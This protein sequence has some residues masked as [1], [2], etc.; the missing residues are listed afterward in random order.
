[1]KA[2]FVQY[3]QIPFSESEVLKG[4]YA[5]PF[6]VDKLCATMVKWDKGAEFGPDEHIDE[7]I[8]FLLEGKME[9]TVKDDDGER[10]VIVT[11]G[12]AIGLDPYVIH[13]GKALEDSL[14]VEIFYPSDRH[15]ERTREIGIIMNDPK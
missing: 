10:T 5:K 6:I 4:V 13:K 14:A 3:D 11:A 9:W 2:L 1:M 7:Q 12:M 8:D 15:I